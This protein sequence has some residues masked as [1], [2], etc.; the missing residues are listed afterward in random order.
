MWRQCSIIQYQRKSTLNMGAEEQQLDVDVLTVRET[1]TILS[2]VPSRTLR[3]RMRPF[4][5]RRRVGMR[6]M[7]GKTKIGEVW[8]KPWINSPR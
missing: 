8:R 6:V 2:S 4:P 5:H 3:T 1:F 7:G